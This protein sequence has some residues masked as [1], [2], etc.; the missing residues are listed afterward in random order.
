MNGGIKHV[1]DKVTDTVGGTVGKMSASTT[2]TADG[3][4]E[5]AAIGNRYEL[6]AARVAMKRTRSEPVRLFARQML[7]D[8]T[9]AMHQMSAALEMNETR[10]IAAPPQ[11]LDTRRETMLKH[12]GEAPDDDFDTTYVDQQVLAH[13]ET[14]SLMRSYAERGDN[15]QLQ[16]LALGTLPVVERHLQHARRMKDQHAG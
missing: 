14:V 16:S 15:P 12:L 8:H 1:V 13:E 3:F 10:G 6:D 11:A 2:S 7:L 5:S 4:V 9:T